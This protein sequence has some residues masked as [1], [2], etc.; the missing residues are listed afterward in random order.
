M[1]KYV[2]G[3]IEAGRVL[4]ELF[5]EGK[6]SENSFYK[7]R[8]LVHKFYYAMKSIDHIPDDSIRDQVVI[9]YRNDKISKLDKLYCSSF[10]KALGKSI[11][12]A[13]SRYHIV[14]SCD[15]RQN[16]KHKFY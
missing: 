11:I 6:I 12:L 1:D 14:E 13:I 10:A 9:M 4:V 16:P 7:I 3:N 8:R 2:F 5:S 15:A